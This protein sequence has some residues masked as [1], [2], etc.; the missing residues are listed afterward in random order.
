MLKGDENN[1]S[2]FAKLP[3]EFKEQWK[4]FVGSNIVDAFG[5]YLLNYKAFSKII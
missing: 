5:P 3:S 2:S 4:S 1:T